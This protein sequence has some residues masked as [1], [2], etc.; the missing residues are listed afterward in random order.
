MFLNNL[1][2]KPKIHLYYIIQ[3]AI[4][5]EDQGLSFY[6]ALAK[7]TSNVEIKNLCSRLA[8]DEAAHKKFFQDALLQWKD[9][10]AN[11]QILDS[12][13]EQ[14]QNIGLFWDF[15]LSSASEKE[16]IRYAIE[17]EIKTADFYL[18]FEK[19]FPK[20][21]KQLYIQQLVI[22]ERAH[23]NSLANLLT[24]LK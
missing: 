19:N 6:T 2:L 16:F 17:Q 12:L 22:T 9:P 13:T 14:L 23:A 8:K 24:S 4:S 1:K 21:W 10:V 3:I 5:I 7:K 20:T 11:D 15:S 18:S